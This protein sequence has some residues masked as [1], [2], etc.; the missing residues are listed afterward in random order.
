MQKLTVGNTRKEF[1]SRAVYVIKKQTEEFKF[2]DIYN[3]MIEQCENE[4]AKDYIY[5]IMCEALE[6]CLS[7]GCVEFI[8]VD[9]YSVK[10]Q[11]QEV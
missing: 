3:D 8:D 4:V 10:H 1:E 11:K 6:F 9:K 5:G 7:C 2:V